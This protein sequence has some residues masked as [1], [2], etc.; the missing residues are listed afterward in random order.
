[1]QIKGARAGRFGPRCQQCSEKFLLVIEGPD[2]PPLIIKPPRKPAEVISPAVAMALGIEMPA[3]AR[4]RQASVAGG[5]QVTL[6]GSGDSTLSGQSLGGSGVGSALPSLKPQTPSAPSDGS[7]GSGSGTA[8]SAVTTIESAPPPAASIPSAQAAPPAPAPVSA[9][10]PSAGRT[11]IPS[12]DPSPALGFARGSL[13]TAI[14]AAERAM[15][16]AERTGRLPADSETPSLPS[17]M[18]TSVPAAP[19]APAAAPPEPRR[20]NAEPSAASATSIP[21]APVPAA[22]PPSGAEF[23]TDPGLRRMEQ[24]G[25]LGGYEVIKKLGQGGMGAVYLARQ[26]SLDRNVAVKILSPELAQDPSFVARFTR[27]AYAAAQLTHHNIV[28]IH[29]IGEENDIHYFSMEFVEGQTLSSTVKQAKH[30]DPE[31]AVGY[32]LQAARGLKFAHD[33]AMIHRDIKPENLLLNDQGLVKVADLGLVKRHGVSEQATASPALAAASDASVTGA[34]LSMGTPAY[35]A[36][37]QARDAAKVDVRADIYSLGCTLYDLLTGRPPFTG[38]TVA[39]VLTKHASEPILP[40]EMIVKNVPKSLSVILVKMMAKRPEDRY[41]S[42]NDVIKALEEFLGVSGGGSGPFSPREEHARALETAVREFR[43]STWAR[44]RG[45]VILGYFAL[46]AILTLTMLWFA[47]TGEATEDIT[48]AGGFLGLGILS[49]VSYIALTGMT[50]R[51]YLFRKLRQYVFGAQI[52]DWLKAL[53]F[54]VVLIAMLKVFGLIWAWLGFLIA[55]ILLAAALHF[56]LD[57]LVRKQ[58]QPQIIQMESMFKTMR[59]RG[60]DEDALRQ[61]VCKYSGGYWEEFYEALFG[62]ES[63][64]QARQNWGTGVRARDRSKKWGA[65]RDP[66]IAWIDARMRQRQEEKERKFLVKIE[67]RKLRAEGV[68]QPAAKARK[69]AGNFVAKVGRMKEASADAAAVKLGTFVDDDALAKDD[70]VDR[71]RES[72]LQRKYG[73]FSGLILG[74][75]VRFLVGLGLL[76]LFF[77]WFHGKNPDFPQNFFHRAGAIIDAT[78]NNLSAEDRHGAT[79]DMGSIKLNNP[80]QAVTVNTDQAVGFAQQHGVNVSQNTQQEISSITNRVLNITSCYQ[81]GIAGAILVFSAFFRGFKMGVF[82]F[83]ATFVLLLCGGDDRIFHLPSVGSFDRDK[84][85]MIA[86]SGIALLGFL[87][88]RQ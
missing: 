28:Q 79:V 64:I 78:H 6:V 14:Q 71:K 39:E 44:L 11:S 31:A 49:F 15:D 3:P 43:A 42:M 45:F 77:L 7:N 84:I 12:S 59:L 29:D 47:R 2:K 24:S 58:R 23:L 19:Q 55:G 75:Q 83:L 85:A 30:L 82:M 60:L 27:E 73:G 69:V 56:T 26:G 36:P 9:P 4:H 13:A 53:L 57:V 18:Q 48:L 68:D 32:V 54:A 20:R 38:K 35:M 46:C 10:P 87:F 41:A 81:A 40:P 21:V 5:T 61:F 62:Y 8:L 88:G 1:M 34:A 25:R 50:Q 67:E 33:H 74:A 80:D 17:A 72:Y 63:K 86:G 52:T 76:A 66:I 70:Y 51:T 16:R 22:R 37:E 65:W